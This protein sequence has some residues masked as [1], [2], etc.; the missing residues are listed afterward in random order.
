MTLQTTWKQEAVSSQQQRA[1]PRRMSTLGFLK[2]KGCDPGMAQ[3]VAASPKQRF[4]ALV[5][6]MSV[7]L[8]WI[9]CYR[10]V[11]NGFFV[12]LLN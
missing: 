2:F 5:M 1:L 10:P 9:L 12:T 4:V 8:L 6:I 7:W 11:V 3:L